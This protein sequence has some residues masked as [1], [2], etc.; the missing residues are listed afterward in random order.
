M[1]GTKRDKALVYK[2]F[3]KW[4]WGKRQLL[5]QLEKFYPKEFNRYFEPFV[6]WGAVFFDLRNKFWDKFPAHVIDINSEMIVTY[7]V[8]KNNVEWLIKEL[9][10]YKYDKELFLKVRARDRKPDF[11]KRSDVQRAARFIYLN[12]TSF[13]WLYRVNSQGFYN[14]PFGRYS[15]PTICDI[16]T[17]RAA[18]WALKN[19][20]IRNEDFN[21]ILKYAKKWDFIYF[22]PPYDP[23]TETAKF[24]SY[25]KL[26]FWRKEQEKLFEVYKE[27]DK[28]WC[29]LMLSNHNTQFINKLYK[30]YKIE[31]VYATRTIN[32]D[33]S[34]RGKIEETVILNY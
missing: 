13:N 15:N 21:N 1:K 32:S 20:T 9:K 22:D 6:G 34:K 23:L 25:D 11:Q 26:G 28:R 4:V 16:D 14:V 18:H 24:T 33:S 5:S 19:T 2:P 27:L 8:I 3:I 10:K 30:E 31:V 29:L 7:N 17:L 12:R